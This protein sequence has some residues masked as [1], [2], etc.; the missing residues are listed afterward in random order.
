[1]YR[2]IFLFPAVFL[3]VIFLSPSLALAQNNKVVPNKTSTTSLPSATTTIVNSST[4]QTVIPPK[5]TFTTEPTLQRAAQIRLNNL[6][7]NLSNRMDSTVKRLQN[8]TDRLTSRLNKMSEAGQNVESARANLT[9]AQ[10]K[11]D[12]AKKNLLTIDKEVLAFVGSATPRENWI[13][14]KNTYLTTRDA[15]VAAHTSI[16]ATI[17]LAKTATTGT[18]ATSTSATTTKDN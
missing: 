6:A 9:V 16:L 5:K 15:I 11:L 13:N 7:A 12:E 18:T 8:V 4:S 17:E 1:M 14:L 3:S 10:V 2:I